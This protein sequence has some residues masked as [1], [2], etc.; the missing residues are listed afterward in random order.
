MKENHARCQLMSNECRL[1]LLLLHLSPRQRQINLACVN[2]A[3]SIRRGKT[4][5]ARTHTVWKSTFIPHHIE[6]APRSILSPSCFP[7]LRRA[8]RWWSF[9]RSFEPFVLSESFFTEMASTTEKPCLGLWLCTFH[10]RPA[11]AW[12]TPFLLAIKSYFVCS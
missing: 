6:I 3:E 5:R 10:N 12:A 1:L 8:E 9:Q 7:S 11:R 2:G 4:N